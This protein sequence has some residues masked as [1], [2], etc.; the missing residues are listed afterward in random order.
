[1]KYGLASKKTAAGSS[2]RQLSRFMTC[3]LFLASLT[4]LCSC[5]RC[6]SSESID[7]KGDS[8]ASDAKAN[9]WAESVAT[10]MVSKIRKGHPRIYLTPERIPELKREALTSKKYYFDLL[11]K[12]MKGTQA[13]LFYALDADKALSL[14][15]TRAEY[16]RI[17]A[18]ELMK[19][20]RTNS[21][22]LD[23]R[24]L[25]IIYDWAYGAL[26]DEEKR[27]FVSYCKAQIGKEVP[28]HDNRKH[29]YR[30]SPTPE[31]IIPLLA[32]YGD[33][34]DDAYAKN[35]L[36]Q[37]IRDALLDNLAMEHVGGSKG[38]YADGTSYF[39]Q[40]GGTFYPFLAL[41]IATNSDFFFEHEA[42]VKMPIHLIYSTLPFSIKRAGAK[43]EGKGARYFATFHDNFTLTAREFGSPGS[44]LAILFSITAAEYRRH[45]E[46]KRASL[47]SWFVEDAFGGVPYLGGRDATSFVLTDSSIQPRGPAEVGLPLVEALGWDDA[48]GQIDRDRFGKKAG[49]GWV[50]MRSSWDNPDATF[51]IFKSEPFY[52]HGHMHRDSLAFMIAKGEELALA[53]AGNYMVWYEGGPLKSEN[54]GW[55]QMKDF[56]S[57]TISTNNLLVYDPSEKYREFSNDGGQRSTKYWD[58]KWGRTYNGT[59]N[60]NYRDI[61]GL[62]RFEETK[63][64][65]YAAADATRAYNST[66]VTSEG[67]KPKVSLVQRE[68]VY[69][70]SQQG[71]QD[72]FVVYDRIDSINPEFKKIW[73]LQL[74]AKPEFDGKYK[75]A[76]GN[77][78]GG[79]H[80][81]ED[82]S[83]IHVQQERAELFGKILLPKGGNRLVRRLGGWMTTELEE[84]L[85]KDDNGPLDIEVKSTD[86]LPEHP[87]V[88]ITSEEPDPNREIFD[89]FSVWPQMIHATSKPVGRRVAYFCDGKTQ[90][91]HKPAKLLNCIRATRS[92]PGFDMPVG[93]KVIQEFRH[94]GIQGI[95]KGKD[96]ERIDYPWGYGLG[97]NYGDGN[98]YGLWRIE[99]SPKKP[100]KYDN[101]L[102]GLHPAFKG[103]G[104]LNAELIESASGDTYGAKVG[105]KTVL[106]SKN[107]EPLTKGSFT[108]AGSGTLW[109]L[110]CDLKPEKKY[111]V[112]QDGKLLFEKAASKQGTIQFEAAVNGTD[113]LFEF[114]EAINR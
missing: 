28:I 38:G 113:S 107:P 33:G 110:L 19:G 98:Q 84:P 92:A 32:F 101:F 40:L 99:V 47:Y 80:F 60:G 54:P 45:G 44:A 79:I 78:M 55:P 48:K 71:D 46:E 72:N 22:E 111:Q 4:L 52:Y 14:P 58:D 88:I 15:K 74:R 35:L 102:H 36:T 27:A 30:A 6:A 9:E 3:L 31:G 29:G 57:R 63:D 76:V 62:I 43:D 100:S 41:G 10:D 103:R 39:A 37:G 106:F 109:Q 34:F 66:L 25:A 7:K 16:G 73:L 70:R 20:I 56:F 49:I 2:Y 105:N 24:T 12:R 97:Y 59:D 90:P 91:D 17:A 13:A 8:S 11:I 23:I 95:D 86:G 67:N 81:S 87:V 18:D 94:M 51:A 75:V 5:T 77:D 26:T 93:A 42:V 65:V 89:R 61:G 96:S 64:Y 68:F 21:R 114:N 1:M 69:L 53:R 50:S 104:K 112:K 108:V 83:S 82:T 85:K